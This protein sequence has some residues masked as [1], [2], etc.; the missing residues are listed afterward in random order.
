M[1]SNALSLPDPRVVADEDRKRGANTPFQHRRRVG[2]LRG[3]GPEP[4]W[5]LALCVASLVTIPDVLAVLTLVL[6]L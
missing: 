5:N 6:N 3:F 2:A 4:Q 1:A